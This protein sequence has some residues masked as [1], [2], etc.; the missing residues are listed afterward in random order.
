MLIFASV[1][2]YVLSYMAEITL[3]FLCVV[4]V[5]CILIPVAFHL[6]K[7]WMQERKR[8][9]I[10]RFCAYLFPGDT[11][12]LMK[13]RVVN[14]MMSLTGNRFTE[15]E[16]LDYYLKIKGLQ[17]IDLNSFNDNDMRKFLMRPTQVRLQY[18]EL[19]IFYEQFLNQSEAHGINVEGVY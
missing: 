17:M 8:K 11:D 12:G 14:R 2:I 7:F 6:Y 10:D 19:V 16:V 15:D 3:S 9:T 1:Y 5:L 13:D 4:L 18:R